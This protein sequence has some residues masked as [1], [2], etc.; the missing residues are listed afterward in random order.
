RN[1]GTITNCYSVG[2]IEGYSYVGGLVGRNYYGTISNCYSEGDVSGRS[3][4]SGM[5]VGGLV[6][7]NGYNDEGT[8][9]NCYAE[10]D[11]SGDENVGGLVGYNESFAS[12][13]LDHTVSPIPFSLRNIRLTG[14]AVPLGSYEMSGAIPLPFNFNFYDTDFSELFIS[15]NGYITFLS[16][17]YVSSA[18][19][20]PD[21]YTPNGLIAGFWTYM[22][23]SVGGTIRYQTLGSEGSRQ[24]VIGFYNVPYCC[25]PGYYPAT[26][27]IILH[28]GTNNI[29]LQYGSTPSITLISVGIENFDGTDGLQVAYGYDVSLNY[30]GFLITPEGPVER[31]GAISR[32]YS[33]GSVSGTTNVGGLLGDNEGTV[34][35]SF[36]D[37]ETS[38]QSSSDGGTGLPTAEMQTASTFTDAR[39]DFNTPVWTIDEGV[40]YPHLWWELAPLLHAEPEVTLWTSNTISW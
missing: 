15:S 7:Y 9:I 25:E 3:S 33:T 17:Q 5:Y 36:W 19:P 20:L 22:D 11:V 27:E 24:F 21:T 10:G 16:G 26:F 40:D 35:L 30:E 1:Y 28:E 13:F 29:E 4:S 12:I 38:G 37:T 32:S 23:P 8:I 2:G 39:W 31:I 18:R 6:G 14:T 34:Y